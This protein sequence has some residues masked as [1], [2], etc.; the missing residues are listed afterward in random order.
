MDRPLRP[1]HRIDTVLVTR[2]PGKP[3]KTCLQSSASSCPR[4]P[5]P[6]QDRRETTDQENAK[7]LRYVVTAVRYPPI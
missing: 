3:F 2:R 6:D 1:H 7:A 5:L 4:K